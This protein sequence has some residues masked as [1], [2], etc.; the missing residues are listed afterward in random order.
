MFSKKRTYQMLIAIVGFAFVIYNQTFKSS[1]S[2]A[3]DSC[4]IF[5]IS[6][7]LLLFLAYMYIKLDK[8]ND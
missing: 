2:E 8:K 6:I 3:I 7:A 5:L 4:I 1:I